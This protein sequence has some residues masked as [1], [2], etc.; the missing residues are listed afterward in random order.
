[1]TKDA[2]KLMNEI[3]YSQAGIKSSQM[4]LAYEP[5]AAAL[6]CSL[7]PEDQGI[8]KYFQ[9]RRRLMIVDLGGKYYEREQDIFSGRRGGPL[10]CGNSGL[11]L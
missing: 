6:F 10:F 7:L 3:F 8:A 1:M 5:E 2:C 11:G 4:M 9:E